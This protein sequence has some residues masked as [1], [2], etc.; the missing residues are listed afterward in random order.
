M[1]PQIFT[2][3]QLLNTP[4]IPVPFVEKQ[5]VT[6][7]DVRQEVRNQ[8]EAGG[9]CQMHGTYSKASTAATLRRIQMEQRSLDICI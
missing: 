7:Q 1:G 2:A 8:I 3:G 9:L 6:E 5:V 4:Q